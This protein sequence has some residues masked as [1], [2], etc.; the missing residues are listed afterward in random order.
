LLRDRNLLN[1][2]SGQ[3]RPGA[4]LKGIGDKCSPACEGCFRFFMGAIFSHFFGA[5][6]P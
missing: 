4:N 5:F 2:R 3:Q 6:M 1:C